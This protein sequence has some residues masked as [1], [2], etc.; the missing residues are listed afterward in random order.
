MSLL[1]TGQYLWIDS[2]AV[3]ANP[4][5]TEIVQGFLDALALERFGMYVFDY[6]A[7]VGFN[8]AVAHPDRI[9]TII[10]QN[11]NAYEERLGEGPWELLRAYLKQP[12]E[13]ADQL[14][15][16]PY[17]RETPQSLPRPAPM[18]RA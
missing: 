14:Q 17:G 8:L 7:P 9:T 10:S 16:E 11:G 5:L 18:Q 15:R 2:L 3:I 4:Q 12:S 1:S 6:G 13:A